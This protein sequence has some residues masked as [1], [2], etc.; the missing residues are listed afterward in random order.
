[1]SKFNA[2]LAGTFPSNAAFL[3]LASL[4]CSGL[5]NCLAASP[6]QI[7]LKGMPNLCINILDV[8][9]IRGQNY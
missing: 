9:L 7:I 2:T 1:M 6:L 4:S 8:S 3:V 5:K